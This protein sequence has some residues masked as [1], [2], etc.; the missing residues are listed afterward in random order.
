M[1]YSVRPRA[2]RH[3]EYLSGEHAR[4]TL[5]TQYATGRA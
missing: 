1:W 2:V 5:C 4:S 3:T